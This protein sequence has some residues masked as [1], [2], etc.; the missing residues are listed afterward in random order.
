[1]LSHRGFAN[2]PA[3]SKQPPEPCTHPESLLH[4]TALPSTQGRHQ[5]RAGPAG[6]LGA[7]SPV[8]PSAAQVVPVM[9]RGSPLQKGVSLLAPVCASLETWVLS[10]ANCAD[11][12]PRSTAGN[13]QGLCVQRRNGPQPSRAATEQCSLLMA[14]TRSSAPAPQPAACPAPLGTPLAV[15][16]GG[17]GAAMGPLVPAAGEGSWHQHGL[18]L[19]T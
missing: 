18:C 9:G 5:H 1:M 13:S 7:A 10:H 19:V 11:T 16:G 17:E 6:R 12:G 2:L 8:A 15:P 4:C 14:E 3:D